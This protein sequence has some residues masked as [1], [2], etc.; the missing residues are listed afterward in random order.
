MTRTQRFAKRTFDLAASLT[1]LAVLS[2]LL[3]LA[4][5]AVKLSSPGPVLF[6]QQRVGRRGKLF[7]CAKF[8]T[9]RVGAEA[10]GS[11]TTASDSRVTPV[12]RVLR[13]LKLD[14]LPQLWNVLVGEMSLVGPRPDVP[15]YADKLTGDARRVLELRPGITGPATLAFR[16]EEA[17]LAQTGNPQEYNDTVLWPKKVAL[18]LAY[19][20]SWG[21]WRDLGYILATMV[22][23]RRVNRVR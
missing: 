8:R 2:P 12:G 1:G 21:F 16:D 20:D 17:L 4:A 18:N 7:Y 6:R 15:G 11:V 14:E 9:M 22:P 10:Q 3:A 5:V 13:R 23:R 19:L